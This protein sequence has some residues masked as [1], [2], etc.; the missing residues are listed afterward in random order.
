M[1]R[2]IPKQL[3]SSRWSA[4]Q[5]AILIS[6]VSWSEVR[7][8]CEQHSWCREACIALWRREVRDV[9]NLS[10]YIIFKGLILHLETAES[11]NR[12]Y[13]WYVPGIYHHDYIPGTHQVY[14]KIMFS[15]PNCD[16]CILSNAYMPSMRNTTYIIFRALHGD[17]FLK[18]SMVLNIPMVYYRLILYIRLVYTWN[19]LTT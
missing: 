13:T 12:I 19:I 7:R 18:Y 6:R 3:F 14:D 10:R 1:Y 4:F 15:K 5:I 16:I 2:Y 11:L 8:L 17:S 9:A